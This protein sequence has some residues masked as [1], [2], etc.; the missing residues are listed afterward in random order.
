[1]HDLLLSKR[2]VAAPGKHPLRVAVERNKARLQAEFTKAR[3]RRKC[4]GVEELRKV[5]LKE[6]EKDENRTRKVH[7]RW[8]RVNDILSSL[9][10]QLESTFAK[11]QQVGRLD[12]LKENALVLDPNIP[13]LV[14]LPPTTNLTKSPAYK[15]GHVILQDKASCFPAYLLLQSDHE[16]PVGDVID[17]CAAPGNKT[18]HLAAILSSQIST[19]IRRIFACERDVARSKTLQMMIELAGASQMVKV[20]ARQDFL[21][22][23]HMH[24]DFENVTHLLLDP[25]CS[26]S[27]ILGREDIPRLALPTD[28]KSLTDGNG[29]GVSKKRKR[30]QGLTNA[31]AEIPIV[32]SE[33]TTPET[34]ID[35][36]R[37]HRLSS[38][39]LRILIHAFAFPSAR[40][41]TYST[42][43]THV[44]ENESVV[45]RALQSEV[46]KRRG[47]I[48]LPRKRQAA[49]LR[50]WHWRGVESA[51][52]NGEHGLDEEE[53]E[54]CIRCWPGDDKGTMGFFVC[55][56]VRDRHDARNGTLSKE[57]GLN[58]NRH[59]DEV[60][61]L[62][63]EEDQRE[64]EWEGFADDT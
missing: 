21:A 43:S 20:K 6:K 2:G 34:P 33:A 30:G 49:G 17:A 35:I 47:W 23:N 28:P 8:V 51:E 58:G 16:T 45:F 3:L 61:A 38:L 18:T 59:S 50:T 31:E 27:G 46:A 39:Q 60:N 63:S 64:E 11:Y 36:D 41:I 55:G 7:P 22:L 26:G 56:F 13:N 52:G 12:D 9:N 10:E 29:N 54:G 4:T 25:S 57:K 62:A 19:S 40:V 32:Q 15:H 44:T 53:R 48:V 5:V 24:P 37:L 14:A 42:C 1:M